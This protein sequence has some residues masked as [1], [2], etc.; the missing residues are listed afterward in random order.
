MSNVLVAG[1]TGY[2]GR[3]LIT[4]LADTDHTVLAMSRKA[5]VARLDPLRESI[6]EIRIADAAVPAS[7]TSVMRDVDAVISTVGLTKPARGLDPDDVDYLANVHLLTAAVNAGVGHFAYVS[8]AGIDLPG[9]TKIA[10]IA[11]KQRFEEVLRDSRICWSIARPSGYFWNYGL[12]LTMARKHATVPMFGTGAAKT[13]P[14]YEADLARVIISGINED[15]LIY[16]AG[17]PED[18]SSNEIA[19]LI[20]EALGRKL[21]QLHIP[22]PLADGALKVI[23]PFAPGQ[24][25]MMS[26]LLWALTAGATADHVGTTRL[27]EWLKAH[28]D[29]T[30][31]L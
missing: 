13:T 9:A 29:D 25:E 8:V 11:A 22:E 1:S 20:A 23:K 15:Q 16:S 21:H 19:E 7:L 3:A 30:F 26:F 6:D 24:Y 4:A 14:I 5:S 10:T 31:E 2:L 27:G 12:W 17:G 18:L 28:R